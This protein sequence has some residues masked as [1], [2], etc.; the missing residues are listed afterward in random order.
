MSSP[1]AQ[2][3]Y[4]CKQKDCPNMFTDVL[5]GN[6]AFG[7]NAKKSADCIPCNIAA[8]MIE[9]NQTPEQIEAVPQMM[10]LMQST[11][12]KTGWTWEHVKDSL[13]RQPVIW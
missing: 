1:K 5:G 12:R 11:L 3:H 10:E 9:N 4:R 2:R 13:A 6:N 7:A 8:Q